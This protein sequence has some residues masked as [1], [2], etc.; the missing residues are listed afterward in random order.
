MKDKIKLVSLVSIIV[1]VVSALLLILPGQ[2]F[3][4][5]HNINSGTWNYSCS[6]YGYIFNGNEAIEAN[7]GRSKISGLG[8]TALILMV[9]GLASFVPSLIKGNEYSPFSILGGAFNLTSGIMF[10]AMQANCNNIFKD[11]INYKILWVSYVIGALLVLAALISIVAS[12]IALK[13]EAKKPY[14]KSSYSYLKK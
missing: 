1:V 4:N 7:L 12:A 5:G 6:G 8:L 3:G 2:F 10:L 13:N 14:T 9:L 11:K